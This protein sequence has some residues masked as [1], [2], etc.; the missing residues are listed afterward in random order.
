M[1]MKTV[2][3]I[4]I[5]EG[6]VKK[7]ERIPNPSFPIIKQIIWGDADVYPYRRLE[8]V[9]C[10]KDAAIKTGI[11]ASTNTTQLNKFY[12]KIMPTNA[13]GTQQR[14]I[15]NYNGNASLKRKY[16]LIMNNNPNIF[17]NV[18]GGSWGNTDVTVQNN[19]AYVIE[20]SMVYNDRYIKVD[21]TTY[22]LANCTNESGS[23]NTDYG[24]G[25]GWN[26]GNSGFETGFAGRLYGLKAFRDNSSQTWYYIPC[27]RKSDGKV[28]FVLIKTDTSG[29]TAFD[30]FMP[31]T[32]TND[33]G[34]GPVINEYFDHTVAPS[35]GF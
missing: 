8:Y 16:P 14:I 31:S 25:A 9:T 6:S 35:M 24:Y 5:P 12:T 2:K 13:D 17:Q 20:S 15:A 34:A 26:T 7:I 29:T 18:A 33:F 32:W 19:T 30:S 21:D 4:T 3:N 11:W 28:G 1:D 27:Q 10:N 23:N 22:S